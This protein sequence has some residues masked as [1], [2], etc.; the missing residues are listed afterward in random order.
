ML[1]RRNWNML[2]KGIN[3][4]IPHV[5]PIIRFGKSCLFVAEVRFLIFMFGG[6]FLDD[7]LDVLCT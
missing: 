3:I 7:L 6:A 5:F 2:L 1:H 4:L